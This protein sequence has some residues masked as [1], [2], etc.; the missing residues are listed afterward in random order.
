MDYG[1]TTKRPC[2]RSKLRFIE[3][4]VSPTTTTR[5]LARFLSRNKEMV[6]FL[7]KQ[8]LHHNQAGTSR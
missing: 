4:S 5:R 2:A 8:L 3:N 1:C 7:S 6:I